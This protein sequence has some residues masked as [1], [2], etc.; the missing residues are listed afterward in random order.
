MMLLSY[1]CGV[2]CKRWRSPLMLGVV[3]SVTTH[4]TSFS[5]FLLETLTLMSSNG[6]DEQRPGC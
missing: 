6:N 5:V 3:H 2:K 4:S 1:I